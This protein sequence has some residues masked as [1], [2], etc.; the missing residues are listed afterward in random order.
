MSVEDMARIYPDAAAVVRNRN[1]DAWVICETYHHFKDEAFKQPYST[2]PPAF[3]P[4]ET[5]PEATFFQWKCDQVLAENTWDENDRLP[6]LFSKFNNVMR[7][8]LGTHW[9]GG[10]RKDFAVEGIRRQCRL[11]YTSGFNAV[12]LFGEDSTYYPNVEFN[13]LALRY[14]ADNPMN[15]LQQFA[16]DVMAPKLGSTMLAQDYVNMAMNAKKAELLPKFQRDIVAILS[17]LTNPEHIRRWINFA[18]FIGTLAWENIAFQ[19]R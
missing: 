3:K 7:S 1:K 18:D 5:M 16:D 17:S 6:P 2:V 12:S 14:F 15:T 8:H 4:F 19:G 13:Y 9:R 11:S 10:L